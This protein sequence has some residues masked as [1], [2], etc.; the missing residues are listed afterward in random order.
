MA[1]RLKREFACANLHAMSGSFPPVSLH[2]PWVLIAI[3]V[4]HAQTPLIA[5]LATSGLAWPRLGLGSRLRLGLGQDDIDRMHAAA[6][7]FMRAALSAR[8]SDG[9]IRP[10]TTLES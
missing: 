10:Q 7:H 9:A 1:G 5:D 2:G 8:W 3:G 6:A 4:F